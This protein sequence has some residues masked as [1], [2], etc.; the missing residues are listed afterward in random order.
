MSTIERFKIANIVTPSRIRTIA[1]TM[2]RH[3]EMIRFTNEKLKVQIENRK[4]MEIETKT[5]REHLH[6]NKKFKGI[7]SSNFT[8]LDNRPKIPIRKP[9]VHTAVIEDS[10]KL[11]AVFDSLLESDSLKNFR[12]A[13]NKK[14][15]PNER[16]L[17]KEVPYLLKCGN[18]N[19]LNAKGIEIKNCLNN[20]LGTIRVTQL[21]LQKEELKATANLIRI[22]LKEVGYGNIREVK[23]KDGRVVLRGSSDQTSIYTEI[24]SNA[25]MKIDFAG[26]KGEA[27][28]KMSKKFT[29]KLKEK[30]F[31][32]REKKEHFH[33]KSE[34]GE[35]VQETKPLFNV[36]SDEVVHVHANKKGVNQKQKARM[37]KNKVRIGNS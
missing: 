20:V 16:Q 33:D 22:S 17:L 9:A 35:L 4:W 14:L 1:D 37:F 2:N 21:N 31:E 15:L 3:T 34:G 10:E 18:Y 12:T 26:F 24:T 25:E 8:L 23:P 27:C 30:G 19:A 32:I 28:R 6:L 13:V 11:C 7:H 36:F 29:E 5:N